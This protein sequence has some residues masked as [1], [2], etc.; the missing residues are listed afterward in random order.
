LSYVSRSLKPGLPST[1]LRPA[2]NEQR[3]KGLARDALVEREHD[4]G[5]LWAEGASGAGGLGANLLLRQSSDIR[6]S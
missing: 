1:K 2:P 4:R 6:A 3:C 5:F